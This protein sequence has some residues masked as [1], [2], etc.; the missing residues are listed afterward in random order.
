MIGSSLTTSN[1]MVLMFKCRQLLIKPVLKIRYVFGALLHITSGVQQIHSF[2][3]KTQH[4]G[5]CLSLDSKTYFIY[6]RYCARTPLPCTRI[7]DR[8]PL[9]SRNRVPDNTVNRNDCN[10]LEDN[11]CTTRFWASRTNNR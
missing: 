4:L 8:V 7:H 9:A 1:D 5:S 3:N 10:K 6:T 2:S 11:H